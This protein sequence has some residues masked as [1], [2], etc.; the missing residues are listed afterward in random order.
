M[1][2][3]Y[4]AVLVC[5]V[6]AMIVGSIWYGA[7]FGKAWMRLTGCTDMDEAKRKEMQKRSIPLYVV[8]FILVLVQLFVLA[9]LTGSDIMTGIISALWAW[10]GFVLPTVAASCMW[11]NEPRKLAWT[12]F[13]I[14]AGYQLLMFI[15][16]GAILAGWH[17]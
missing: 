10:V 12:R 17:Y 11:T 4:W 3:N 2:L 5:A 7:I 15:I 6:V 8:Q 16:F 14:Q 1:M 9:H 13:L